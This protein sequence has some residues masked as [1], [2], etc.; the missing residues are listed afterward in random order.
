[1]TA[2]TKSEKLQPAADGPRRFQF[3]IRDLLLATVW[4]SL[5]LGAIAQ[6]SVILFALWLAA[7]VGFVVYGATLCRRLTLVETLIVITCAG[8]LVAVLLPSLDHPESAREVVC[9]N[10]L[11]QIGIA[12]HAYHDTYKR[13]PPAYIAD[14]NGKPMHS[15]R[16]LILPFLERKDIYDAYCF[17]EPWDG[18][19][20]RKLA[21]RLAATENPFNSYSCPEDHLKDWGSQET[22]YVVVV[23]PGTAWPG[24]KS[25]TLADVKD[26]TSQVIL[27]VETHDSGIHWMEPRDFH[28]TQMAPRVNSPKGQGISSRHGHGKVSRALVLYAD[29][30]IRYLPAGADPKAIESRLQ[31]ND[32]TIID[33]TFN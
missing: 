1:M 26:G 10:N 17:D 28:V 7:I 16:V 13:L 22:S 21:E 8:I 18:P 30:S 4:I 33:Y 32:G 9:R 24:T 23:G 20:N 5:L 25:T 15:W 3:R 12:L 2:A 29:G 27:V 14:E 19:N 31:I 6:Q 11:K